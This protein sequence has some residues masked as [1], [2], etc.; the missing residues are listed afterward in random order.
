ML[1]LVIEVPTLLLQRAPF[2]VDLTPLVLPLG[3]SGDA[4]PF[5]RVE[6]LALLVQ[7]AT[8]GFELVCKPSG[9]PRQLAFGRN[10][11]SDTVRV[12][13]RS[14]AG[15]IAQPCHCRRRE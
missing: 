8:L 2:R 9:I 5:E 3:F 15:P 14:V 12:G 11:V 1:S 13:D 7:L 4:T 10:L 6:Q